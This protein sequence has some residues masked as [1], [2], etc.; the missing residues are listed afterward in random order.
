MAFVDPKMA[1]AI[2]KLSS[3]LAFSALELQHNRHRVVGVNPLLQPQQVNERKQQWT[4]VIPDATEPQLILT[5]LDNQ[6]SINPLLGFAF[7]SN[8]DR[9][10][11]LLTDRLSSNGISH[12]HFHIDFNWELE[13]LLIINK[14]THGT[15]LQLKVAYD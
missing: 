13:V 1:I 10:D 7:G 14:S 3:L 15:H 12:V 4:P 8:K 11:I 5:L 6:K 9:Y 2:L